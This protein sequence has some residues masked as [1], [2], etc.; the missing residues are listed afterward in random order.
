MRCPSELADI[1]LD[2]L[3][4]GILRIRTFAWQGRSEVCAIESDHI[5]NIPNL[6]MNY[7]SERLCYYWDTERAEYT[8]QVSGEDLDAWIALWQRLGQKIEAIGALTTQR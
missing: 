2:I 8:R 7:S 6:I 5:H 3:Q 1:L 4:T